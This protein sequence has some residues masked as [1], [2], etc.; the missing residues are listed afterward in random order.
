MDHF[1]IVCVGNLV[2]LI[3]RITH[4]DTTQR[5]T[6][7]GK[8][9]RNILSKILL[10][11]T[12]TQ[13]VDRAWLTCTFL[14]VVGFFYKVILYSQYSFFC[15]NALFSHAHPTF[16][17]RRTC[18]LPLVRRSYY[19]GLSLPY[20]IHIQELFADDARRIHYCCSQTHVGLEIR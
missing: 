15:C 6:F 4:T 11:N 12:S 10:R 8:S 7:L 1:L 19:L 2:Y 16:P 5:K 3:A 9:V 13:R 20:L 18:S 14:C 17:Q